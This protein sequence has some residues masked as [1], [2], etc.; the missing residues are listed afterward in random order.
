[1]VRVGEVDASGALVPDLPSDRLH[2]AERHDHLEK[3]LMGQ[4]VRRPY[5][6][7]MICNWCGRPCDLNYLKPHDPCCV[8]RPGSD[9]DEEDRNAKA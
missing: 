8:R 6:Y 3:S 9:A 7:W 5:R 4:F 2:P 1:M